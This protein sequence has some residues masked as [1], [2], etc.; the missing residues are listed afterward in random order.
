MGNT[1][2]NLSN[3]ELEDVW[4]SQKPKKDDQERNINSPDKPFQIFSEEYNEKRDKRKQISEQKRQEIHGIRKEL[5]VL[6]TENERLRNTPENKRNEDVKEQLELL[7]Q[8]NRILQEE[9]LTMRSREENVEDIMKKN[10]HLRISVSE[11][12]SELQRMNASLLDFE[13]Q[14]EDYKRHVVALKDV[15]KVSKELLHIRESELN[16]VS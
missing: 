12:Q 16:E 13:E 3:N 5:D 4:W 15:I 8:Q 1:P 10:K 7:K 14:K 2:S 9:I 11:M 6:R